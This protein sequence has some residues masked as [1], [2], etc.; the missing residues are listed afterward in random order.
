MRKKRRRS[1]REMEKKLRRNEEK[2]IEIH[3]ISRLTSMDLQKSLDWMILAS[4]DQ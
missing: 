3:L 4:R 2:P 1:K